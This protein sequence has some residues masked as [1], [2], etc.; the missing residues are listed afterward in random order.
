MARACALTI[1]AHPLFNAAYTPE[2]LARRDRVD[3]GIAIDN[4][5]GLIT[6]VLRDAAG[7]SL[8][9][10]ARGLGHLREKVKSRR[11]APADY[12]GATFYLSEPRRRAR[13][14]LRLRFD[15]SHR[16]LGNPVGRGVRAE[17]RLL[18]LSLRSSGR[19]RRRCR[20]LPPD[21][22]PMAVGPNE[23]DGEGQAK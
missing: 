8:A 22:G 11:L 23:T 19:I 6:P 12:R 14:D 7:R 4:G 20:A 2:G 18:T 17:G 10:L 13:V 9:E 1:T 15:R 5:D 16:R 3:I 21:I